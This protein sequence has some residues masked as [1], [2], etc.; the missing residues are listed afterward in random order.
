MLCIFARDFAKLFYIGPEFPNVTTPLDE[1]AKT[2]SN[3]ITFVL[4]ENSFNDKNGPI[5]YY[6][7]YITPAALKGKQA[8]HIKVKSVKLD[9]IYFPND[10]QQAI[11]HQLNPM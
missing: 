4:P 3:V 9:A 11:R 6:A 5:E 8:L 7:V 10:F 1:D 2:T